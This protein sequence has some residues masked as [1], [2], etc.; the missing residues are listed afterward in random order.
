MRAM[1]GL[2]KNRHG[3]YYAQKMVPKRLREAV[4]QV[5]GNGKAQ[6]VW[7]KKS[8]G[9]TAVGE[10]NVRAKPVQMQFD[11]IIAD[12]EA[13][14][15]ARPL[16]TSL[17]AVEIK[18]MAEYH[19]AKKLAA[20]D[21]Y[22]R[23]A[24]EEERALRQLEPGETWTD[25]VP[26]FGLS[27]GQMVDANAT[28][29]AVLHEAEA[30][31]AQGNIAHIAVQIDDVLSAFQINLDPHSPA[32][33]ELGL[34]LLRAEVRAIRAIQQRHAGEPIETPPVPQ[35]GA[36]AAPTGETLSAAFEGWKR[37]RERPA[38][39]L[40]EYER[41]IRLFTELHGD[42]PI[43]QMKRS[44]ARQ[45]REALQQV[46]R[47]RTG[48]LLKA[49]L[50]ELAEWGR[51]HAEAQKINPGT[52]NKLL[53]GVQAIAVWARDKGGMV[54]D[55]VPWADPFSKM[56][57]VVDDSE[58]APFE[59]EELKAIFS[60]PVFTKGERPIG[61]KG[62]AAF[63]L[64]L[65]GLFTGARR[66]ELAGLRPSD[67]AHDPAIDAISIYFTADRNAGKRLK[68][69]Q[70][71]RVV[72]VHPELIRLGFL[73]FVAVQARTRG[74]DAWLF[75]QI[76]PG[77]S[78]AKD[79]SKWFTRYLHANGVKDTAKVFHSFRHG[80]IDALRAAN[81]GDELNTAL[82]GHSDGKKD[83]RVHA[84]YGAKKIARRFGRLL[85]EAIERVTYPELDLSHL[86]YRKSSGRRQ[87]VKPT[88]AHGKE[89]T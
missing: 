51:K 56:R 66:G 61:G 20:H 45:F 16:R 33:R 62:E 87:A 85:Y 67:V 9:T 53:G 39:T 63:W 42:L 50:P 23:I 78:G 28:I 11:R 14:L 3:T 12:A 48:K 24:P 54:P 19:Y 80:F 52:I 15:K 47:T 2:I 38:A 1:M 60:S 49:P 30:A 73:E 13:L 74:K 5:L 36:P 82:V 77:T 4:A 57:L 17:S 84:M 69:R 26:A 27:R 34:A 76:A 43:V 21:E 83:G 7:L 86:R 6:Q 18:R 59:P 35:I 81:V 55:D 89:R 41:A 65:L 68:N 46:P 58:R 72:P 70:S 10:A 8:L 79:W 75:P 88:Q 32:Y 37:E 64:P 31:L 71:V 22:L 25:T 40:A 29:P 44:H